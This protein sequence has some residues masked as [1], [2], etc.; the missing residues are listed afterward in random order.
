MAIRAQVASLIPSKQPYPAGAADAPQVLRS[1]RRDWQ[2]SVAKALERHDASLTQLHQAAREDTTVRDKILIEDST[3]KAIA[4]IGTFVFRGTGVSATNYFSEIHVGDPLNT[5]NPALALFNAN[6]DGSVTIGQN[7]WL[8]VLDPYGADA[9]WIGTQFDTLAVT[10]AANNGSGLIR[11]TVV[12]HPLA[13]GDIVRV[14]NVGGVPNATGIRTVTKIDADHFDLQATVFV[15]AYTSGGTVDR[16]MHVTGAVNNGSGLIR[17][18]VTAHGYESGDKVNV[19]TVGGVPN[20]AGQW[21]VT[22]ITANTFDLVGSTFAG[23]Y[24][25]GGTSLRYFAGGNFQTIAVGGPTFADYKLRAFADGTLRIKNAI[26]DLSSVA[27]EIILDPSVPSITITSATTSEIS[28]IDPVNGFVQTDGTT[29]FQALS[30]VALI[31]NATYF[32]RVAQGTVNVGSNVTGFIHAR[33]DADGG[34]GGGSVGIFTSAGAAYRAGLEV[35]AGHGALC[36]GGITTQVVGPR[37]AAITT[38]SGS[39]GVIYTAT[40]QGILNSL[41]TAVNTIISRLQTHGLT[42]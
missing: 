28:S 25:S 41:T 26:I 42:S 16:L 11:I 22:V 9:A 2:E 12:G 23:T 24:T 5:G 14:Q 3:G 35:I 7:G 15:G 29:T 37:L 19:Q 31:S 18:T 30:G 4:A 27:G 20:A 6:T 17:L 21:I 32:A 38:V 36:I 40:E 13:T 39:A 34:S 8:D 1:G 10:G 33:I